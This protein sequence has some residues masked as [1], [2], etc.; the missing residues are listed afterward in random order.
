MLL[1]LDTNHAVL[2]H[3]KADRLIRDEG[4]F[5]YNWINHGQVV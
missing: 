3:T 4:L 2:G 1:V 5:M